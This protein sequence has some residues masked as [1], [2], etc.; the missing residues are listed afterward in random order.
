[1][2][3][4]S[5]RGTTQDVA[6]SEPDAGECVGLIH[7]HEGLDGHREMVPEFLPPKVIRRGECDKVSG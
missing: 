4:H 2:I 3:I 6:V 7:L 5:K 1:L